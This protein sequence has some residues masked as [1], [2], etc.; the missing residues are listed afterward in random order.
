MAILTH[1]Q[2]PELKPE[3]VKN[4]IESRPTK[5]ILVDTEHVNRNN[6]ITQIQ[7]S[8][9]Q[10]DFY[11]QVVNDDSALAG[12]QPGKDALNQAY[13][14]TCNF[15]L[16]VTSPL[17]TTQQQDTASFEV[18]GSANVYPY[19][20]PN[21]GDVF[22]ADIGDG[23]LGIFR[24]TNTEEK[25]IYKETTASIDYVLVAYADNRYNNKRYLD[26][27]AKVIQT[28]YFVKEFIDYHQNPYLTD[29][30]YNLV[31]DLTKHYTRLLD[32]YFNYYLSKEYKTFLV[33]LQSS[34]TYDPYLTSCLVKAFDTYSH[35]LASLVKTFNVNEDYQYK[36]PTVWDLVLNRDEYLYPDIIQRALLVGSNRFSKDPLLEGIYFSGVETVIY[37]VTNGT[38]GEP[39]LDSYYS[40]KLTEACVP[41]LGKSTN[42]RSI[43]NYLG[44]PIIKPA[45]L[46]GY[47]IFSQDFYRR[48]SNL[49]VLEAQLD[50]YIRAKP[51]DPAALKAIV[52]DIPNW[53]SVERFYYI[54]FVL[55]MLDNIKRGI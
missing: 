34:L 36:L 9:W 54:P 32:H 49:S 38:G 10:V 29:Y 40:S 53:G 13:I 52:E 22:V 14:K 3:S 39:K 19:L 6:L 11:S 4:R 5:S 20:K 28:K 31:K 2:A 8:P 21:Q 33:P 25:S 51:N 50:L 26:L 15:I 41:L 47:Y 37:P 44:V 45:W 42:T 17:S 16:K 48:T 35:P 24:I 27:E 12:H 46:Q 30:D 18:T 43:N 55:F 1:K 23:R 7:G